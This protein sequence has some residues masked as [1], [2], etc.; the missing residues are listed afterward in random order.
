[1]YIGVRRS[2]MPVVTHTLVSRDHAH[3]PS[4]EPC[5][6]AMR[7]ITGTALCW[8]GVALLV[9]LLAA[10]MLQL[11]SES[12]GFE[13]FYPLASGHDDRLY[14]DL[15]LRY[16]NG[17]PVPYFWSGYPYVLAGLFLLLAPSL[18]LGKFLN[19]LAGALTVYLGVRLVGDLTAER[20]SRGANGSVVPTQ[21]SHWAGAL[22]TFYPSSLFYSTQLVKDPIL[23]LLGLGALS[24][25]I[26]FFHRPHLLSVVFGAATFGGLYF[27]R[28]YAALALAI[29]LFAFVVWQRRALLI[30]TIVAAAAVPYALGWGP[31]GWSYL[32][33][34][35]NPAFFTRF[36]ESVYSIGGSAAGITLD[37]SNP[38]AF[39]TSYGYSFATA[40]FGPF[41]WQVESA[42]Q[43]IAL[44][45]AMAM[46]LLFPIWVGGIV[47]LLRGQ[48]HD[49]ALLLI[50]SLVLVGAIA[51]FSDNIGA[52]TR[53]RLL[54][55]SSFLLYA[56]LRMPR[57]TLS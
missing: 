40:M 53:L 14:W 16:R 4:K 34:L 11:Y 25:A 57:V 36:R 7:D 46:W 18:E 44:P 30:P 39:L 2:G 45:E 12:R 38:V 10:I 50:F 29:S 47:R 26:H 9:R 51:L 48:L 5:P 19:V 15:A 37:F 33:F 41:P 13:G 56:A 27:F 32:T 42:V 21:A 55:W 3:A 24:L 52:N 22:L 28:G 17:E 31:F 23:I 20:A 8:F 35:L 1:M 43:L 54:P 6:G 49:E